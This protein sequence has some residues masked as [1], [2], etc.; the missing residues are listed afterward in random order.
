MKNT[1]LKL[2]NIS[3]Q[4]QLTN[5]KANGK[6]IVHY[7]EKLK[8]NGTDL[9]IFPRD[10][11]AGYSIGDIKYN[12]GLL[13]KVALEVEHIAQATEGSNLLVA[14]SAISE[15]NRKVQ[16]AIYIIGKGKVL[17]VYSK[18][19]I[20]TFNIGI[21][22]DKPIIKLGNA[23]VGFIVG[24]FIDEDFTDALNIVN[25]CDIII[26]FAS[27]HNI[28]SS[29]DKIK[30]KVIA[31]SDLYECCY[32]YNSCGNGESSTDYYYGADKAIAQLG[33]L[34]EEDTML[35][36]GEETY[37]IVNTSILKKQSFRNKII[38]EPE[39][40][41]DCAR[42]VKFLEYTLS[43][44]PYLSKDIDS[45]TKEVLAIQARALARR[46]QAAKADK[47][48]IGISG[49]LDSTMALIASYE[50]MRLLNAPFNNIIAVTMPCF[51]TSGRTYQNALK[52]FKQFGVESL[53][54]NIKEAVKSH[55]KD[56]GHDL[57]T[58]DTAYENAQARERT[59]I[60]LDLA[61]IKN[62]LVVGTGD[63]SEIALGFATYS[64][65]HMSNYSINASL[66]K[67]L[68][69]EI[70]EAYANFR[71][72]ELA[73][74]LKDI[75][76][77]PISPELK[78]DEQ[79]AQKTED[80]VGPYELIDFFIYYHVLYFVS[81]EELVF[82]VKAA[83]KDR[84]DEATIKK[85]L[86]KFYKRFFANQF[87]R[88]CSVDGP[89]ITEISLSPRCGLSMASDIDFEDWKIL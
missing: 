23:N 75:V 25:N 65:D 63:L 31:L 60:L 47:L 7:I 46:M 19:A 28:I 34:I 84:Y 76:A 78:V 87:K 62:G 21:V 13:K 69:K 85:W 45:L 49:G 64:G 37:T 74:L 35:Y 56:I 12:K 48:I 68:M 20:G 1:I 44:K 52:L 80:I 59:Q 9:A 89:A 40:V 88:S 16:E 36:K 83:F 26:Q 55:L 17:G 29:F 3:P 58:K 71:G 38:N 33:K 22:L 54:I 50:C 57:I 79:G 8:A 24:D 51:A 15:V 61:N 2:A 42:S 73:L 72:G 4:I 27:Q 66:P 77:T 10:V 11:I 43:T 39:I 32:I 5:C 41:V 18:E 53:N 70:V 6:A 30:T 67:S 86:N 14:F 81:S 82:L